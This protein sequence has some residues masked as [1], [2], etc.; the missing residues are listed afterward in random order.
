LTAEQLAEAKSQVRQAELAS[1]ANLA[2][3]HDQRLADKLVE[4]GRLNLWQAKQLLEGRAKFNLGPYWIVDFLGHGGMGQVFKARHEVLERVVAVKVLPRSKSTPEGAASFI[5]EMRA[6]AKLDHPNLVRALDAGED[7]NVTYLVTEYVPGADLR[8]RV[9]SSGPLSM[10]DAASIVS[11]V[12]AA[13]HYAHQQGL[14]HRDVKPGNVLVTPEGIAKLSD[15]GLAGPLKGGAEADPRFGKIVGTADYLSPD[16]ITTPWNPTA[17]WDIY[18]LGCTLYYAVTGKVPFPGGSVADKIRAHLELRPLDPRTL[19]PRLSAAFVELMADMMA[20]NPAERIQSAAEVVGHLAP[21][22]N[23]TAPIAR[24]PPPATRH[25]PEPP[26]ADTLEAVPPG[27]IGLDVMDTTFPDFSEMPVPQPGQAS[28]LSQPTHP[29]ASAQYETHPR[30]KV[31]HSPSS[32]GDGILG[33][34]LV[35]VGFPLLVVGGILLVWWLTR[36][37]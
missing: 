36:L 30:L 32:A 3:T 5:R 13:L 2:I 15:L 9:R 22:M 23:P 21:W 29:V 4:A 33:P 11:Q 18:S 17:A 8:R 35:L 37:L 27:L 19:N 25:L 16:H 1:S 31:L 34:L 7:G 28:Q 12:A 14:I 26:P 24:H 10:A 20:K 6:Q